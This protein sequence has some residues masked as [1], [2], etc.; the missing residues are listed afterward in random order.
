LIFLE[1]FKIKDEKDPF[2]NKKMKSIFIKNVNLIKFIIFKRCFNKKTGTN[3]YDLLNLKRNATKKEIKKA[4]FEKS[5]E[6]HPDTNTNENAS[7][8]FRQLKEAYDTLKNSETK[9]DYDQQLDGNA[10]H[11]SPFQ[12]QSNY[13]QRT[14]KP[15]DAM[16]R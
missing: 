9:L 14:W 5:K 7:E 2:L 8:E 12:S 6:L 11:K 15:R 4:Y 3:H 16:N 13:R 10:H 1:C